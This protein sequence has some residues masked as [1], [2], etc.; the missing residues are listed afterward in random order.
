[1]NTGLSAGFTLALGLVLASAATASDEP[2]IAG[3][4]AGSANHA[5]LLAALKEAKLFAPLDKPNANVTVFAPTDAAFRKLGDDRV[6][7]LIRDRELLRS[8]VLA[9]EVPGQLP[10][11]ELLKLNGRTIKTTTGTEFPVSVKG[12]DLQIGNATITIRDVKCSNGILHIVDA[13]LIP[14]K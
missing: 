7:A 12:N 13:V 5:I 1:M 14:P 3:K 10:A 8:L 6:Q 9:H 4:I 11:A 2:T